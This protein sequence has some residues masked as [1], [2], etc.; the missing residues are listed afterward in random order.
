[1]VLQDIQAQNADVKLVSVQLEVAGLKASALRRKTAQSSAG[2]GEEEKS[3]LQA[4]LE[5]QKDALHVS[6]AQNTALKDQNDKLEANNQV[7]ACVH[8]AFIV[9]VPPFTLQKYKSLSQEIVM[10]RQSSPG[11]LHWRVPVPLM[12][13]MKV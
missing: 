1:M 13:V 3:V 10:D 7:S 11:A 6:H 4:N 5:L 2:R 8:T 9:T 12:I